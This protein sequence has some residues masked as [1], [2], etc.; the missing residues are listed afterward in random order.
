[1]SKRKYCE[2][3]EK[4]L[5][6]K[7]A[8]SLFYHS[9]LFGR[10]GILR[11]HVKDGDVVDLIGGSKA[12]IIDDKCKGLC[13]RSLNAVKEETI[14]ATAL[15]FRP[16]A[17]YAEAFFAL[18]DRKELLEFM[19][20]VELVSGWVYMFESNLPLR[21][22]GKNGSLAKSVPANIGAL[23]ESTSCFDKANCRIVSKFYLIDE[24]GEYV[25]GLRTPFSLERFGEI[26]FLKIKTKCKISANSR[27]KLF[28]SRE[29]YD[30]IR[31]RSEYSIEVQKRIDRCMYS[32]DRILQLYKCRACGLS[33]MSYK[34]FEY[35]LIHY[36]NLTCYNAICVI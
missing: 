16:N 2:D 20:G 33:K 10:L 32:G 34:E 13:V 28:Y 19:Y 25:E 27:L 23:L 3:N 22:K 29:F 21:T 35:H 12:E 14:I 30:D 1:M 11:S 17:Y 9:N 4:E 8:L 36:R 26:G 6:V 24:M 15:V 7:G 5:E 31:R 18:F